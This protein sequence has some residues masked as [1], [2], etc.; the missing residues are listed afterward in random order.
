MWPYRSMKILGQDVVLK[1]SNVIPLTE[2]VKTL[3]RQRKE[4]KEFLC[5]NN[6]L[7]KARNI[8]TGE[9]AVKFS[10]EFDK[11]NKIFKDT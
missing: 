2:V 8:V 9:D 10:L 1:K 3:N 4:I 6:S 5:K 7:M 11:N